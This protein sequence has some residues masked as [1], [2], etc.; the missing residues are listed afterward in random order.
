MIDDKQL[1]SLLAS[2][3]PAKEAPADLL[4]QLQKS[5]DAADLTEEYNRREERC[6]RRH[7]AVS[8]AAGIIVGILT[9]FAIWHLPPPAEFMQALHIHSELLTALLVN[10]RYVAIAANILITFFAV[11]YA[12]RSKKSFCLF[13]VFGV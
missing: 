8:F 3:H 7:V 5:M 11:Q 10:G 4:A 13:K 6:H 1:D 2:Y 9:A 12:I